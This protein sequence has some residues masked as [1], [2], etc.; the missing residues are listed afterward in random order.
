[1]SKFAK[2]TKVYNED[3]NQTLAEKLFELVKAGS[4]TYDLFE[5]E[6]VRLPGS[7]KDQGPTKVVVEVKNVY[8]K[9]IKDKFE[10][11]ETFLG[12]HGY[13]T[14]K[15]THWSKKNVT[16][17]VF[18]TDHYGDDWKMGSVKYWFADQHHTMADSAI[19]GPFSK[20]KKLGNELEI[21]V[22]EIMMLS[23]GT[24][25]K[26]FMMNM[27]GSWVLLSDVV[28]KQNNAKFNRIADILKK[29]AA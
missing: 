13:K 10:D 12:K 7:P 22:P 8:A 2:Y 18:A 26:D 21:E 23:N 3:P 29:V 17:T 15:F 11:T 1:M 27:M 19:G 5:V 16:V 9:S 14:G 4:K 28:K 25:N 20:Y 6:G 24:V